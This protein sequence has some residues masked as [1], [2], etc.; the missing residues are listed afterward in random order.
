MLWSLLARKTSSATIVTLASLFA[1]DIFVPVAF[2]SWL[3]VPALVDSNRFYNPALALLNMSTQRSGG[4]WSYAWPCIVVL[5]L[6]A[7]VLTAVLF[8]RLRRDLG[9]E[10]SPDL[11]AMTVTNV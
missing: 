3:R 5:A 11:P 2:S 1:A 6:G 4:A 7:S 8:W 10:K 9:A